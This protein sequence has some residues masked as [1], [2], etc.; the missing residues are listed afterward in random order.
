[1]NLAEHASESYLRAAPM[2]RR[3]FNQA[4]FTRVNVFQDG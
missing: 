2:V 3:R 4:F 1:M